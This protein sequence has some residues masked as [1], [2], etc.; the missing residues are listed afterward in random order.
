MGQ[1]STSVYAGTGQAGQPGDTASAFSRVE[2]YVIEGDISVIPGQLLIQG[3]ADNQAKLATAAGGTYVG[4]VRLSNDRKIDIDLGTPE[5]YGQY[6]R[7]SCAVEQVWHALTEEAVAKGEQVYVR[8]T[9]GAGGSISGYCR[10][11]AD[12][13]SA[14]AINAT[15][16]ETTTAAGIAKIKLHLEQV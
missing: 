5:P 6:D 12:T 7:V 11:D 9:S 8:F 16:A 2:G 14:E 3:T 4:L 1:A 13:A 10:N 15:F